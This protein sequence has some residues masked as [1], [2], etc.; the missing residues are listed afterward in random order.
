MKTFHWWRQISKENIWIVQ[1]SWTKRTILDHLEG[2]SHSPR[3]LTLHLLQVIGTFSTIPSNSIFI[4]HPGD[5]HWDPNWAS[6]SAVAAHGGSSDLPLAG[7]GPRRAHPLPASLLQDS[8]QSAAS[9]G[10]TPGPALKHPGPEPLRLH[11]Q[12]LKLCEGSKQRKGR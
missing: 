6:S 12:P 9:S 8:Q 1:G 2:I 10:V 7:T 3:K 11:Q 4:Q 5:L